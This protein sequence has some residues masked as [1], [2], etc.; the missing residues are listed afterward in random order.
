MNTE[1]QDQKTPEQELQ[2]EN[3]LAF[4]MALYSRAPIPYVTYALI[5]ANVLVFGAML[6]GGGEVFETSPAYALSWGANY[7]VETVNGQWWRLGTAAFIHYGIIHLL[8]NMSVLYQAGAFIE[9]AFGRIEMLSIYVIAALL[10]GM[11]TTIFHYNSV[12]A[13]A[14][15]AIF[16]LIGAEL[17]FFMAGRYKN[18]IPANILKNQLGSLSIFLLYNIFN[19][20]K[21]QS[22]D[23]WAH[24][25]G[26]I[27]GSLLAAPILMRPMFSEATP[28]A[29]Y[30]KILAAFCV[31][32]ILGGFIGSRARLEKPI[33]DD[34]RATNLQLGWDYIFGH[35]V[36]IN[37]EIGARYIKIAA[38]AGDK[39]AQNMLGELYYYGE[40]VALDKN[41]AAEYYK[42]SA[43]QGYEQGQFA[44]AYIYR[45]GEGVEKDDAEAAKWYEKSAKQ[46]NSTAQLNLGRM[47]ASGEGVPQ[48][49]ELAMKLIKE[50]ALRNE[51]DAQQLIG[52]LYSEGQIFPK[53]LVESY[54]WLSIASRTDEDSKKFL[55]EVES[56]MTAE[57]IEEAKKLSAEW[58]S[59]DG[60]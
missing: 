55:S 59:G 13:G 45:T 7:P 39:I 14:S 41:I 4:S 38:D 56:I 29:R 31:A 3:A 48:S 52:R 24:A 53:N 25:G 27:A 42:K 37:K 11:A 9:R 2:E 21:D 49:N 33:D 44:L 19:G 22:T 23:G 16:G 6:I 36:A 40:G 17:S 28:K 35:G 32:L 51:I 15:G 5:V 58:K 1:L 12:G 26:F 20:I 57:Q 30:M 10:G 54:R 43:E 47:Y 46:G 8:L 34:G 18:Q 60:K 50:S